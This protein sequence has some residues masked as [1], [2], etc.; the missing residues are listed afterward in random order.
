MPLANLKLNNGIS[1]DLVFSASEQT[2]LQQHPIVLLIS[3][4]SDSIFLFHQFLILK[5]QLKISFEVVHCNY[6][7]RGEASTKDCEFVKILCHTHNVIFHDYSIQLNASGNIQN[8]ARKWR[9]KLAAQSQNKKCILVTGHHKN[10]QL[11]TLIMRAHRSSGLQGLS[12][13]KRWQ[14]YQESWLFRPL[15]SIEK[16]QILQYLQTHKL[17]FRLDESNSSQKYFRNRIRHQIQLDENQ[18]ANILKSQTSLIT[19]NKYLEH[20]ILSLKKNY[21]RGVSKNIWQSWPKEL[22]FRYVKALLKK[23]KH[24]AIEKK[25]FDQIAASPHFYQWKYGILLHDSSGI[26]VFSKSHLK[27][28]NHPHILKNSKGAYYFSTWGL[29]IYI[30]KKQNLKKSHKKNILRLSESTKFP[31][32]LGCVDLQK[33]FHAFG[34]S[35]EKSL[36]TFFQDQK[37]GKYFRSY[38]PVIFDQNQNILAI[39]GLEISNDVRVTQNDATC[40]YFEFTGLNL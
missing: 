22:Q 32:F 39:P 27:N 25:Q 34:R 4:G 10:D 14:P 16:T 9:Y 20:R 5:D 17:A 3:G 24:K 28:L 19:I 35:K 1:S 30:T 2:R 21:P 38:F 33:P 11:E 12:G 26:F 29:Q 18:Q 37:I 36:K 6:N 31:L 15:L 13:I 8:Q 23:Y 40:L 7:L